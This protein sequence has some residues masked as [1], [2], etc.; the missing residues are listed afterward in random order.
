MPLKIKMILENTSKENITW[1][2]GSVFQGVIMEHI[3]FE[4]GEKLPDTRYTIWYCYTC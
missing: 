4:Y 1:N 2:L 3:G